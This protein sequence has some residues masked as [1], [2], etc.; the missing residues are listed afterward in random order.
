M[1]TAAGEHGARHR[2]FQY[3]TR[4]QT[5]PTPPSFRTLTALRVPL[6]RLESCRTIEIIAAALAA[7]EQ[8]YSANF[9]M[10]V[11]NLEFR[12]LSSVVV[13]MLTPEAE[14]VSMI[15]VKRPAVL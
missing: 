4:L 5:K 7:M 11:M 9:S 1:A 15:S 6:P 10:K 3:Y 14:W 8:T 12:F 13:L 2:Q